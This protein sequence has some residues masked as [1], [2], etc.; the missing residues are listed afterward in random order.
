MWIW[1]S[2]LENYQNIS[3]PIKNYQMQNFLSKLNVMED[4]AFCLFSTNENTAFSGNESNLRKPYPLRSGKYD[5]RHRSD[6]LEAGHSNFRPRP[7]PAPGPEEED[8][9]WGLGTGD[10]AMLR[11]QNSAGQVLRMELTPESRNLLRQQNA[12]DENSDYD[13]DDLTDQL[14]KYKIGM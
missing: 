5:L 13:V 9:D 11:T 6:E 12:S 7:D 4:F 1:A 3:L 8:E 2:V 14:A 10:L